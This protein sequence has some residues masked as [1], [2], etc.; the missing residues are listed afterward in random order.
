MQP[1]ILFYFFYRSQFVKFGR[2]VDIPLISKPK[3]TKT[4]Y[5]KVSLH[6]VMRAH[7]GKTVINMK[8]KKLEIDLS[9]CNS[10]RIIKQR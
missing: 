1:N 8:R 10:L 2:L 3:E 7:F 9:F 6:T 4:T 5:K